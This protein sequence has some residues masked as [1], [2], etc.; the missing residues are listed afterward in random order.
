MRR[1]GCMMLTILLLVAGCKQESV[2]E[3]TSPERPDV[4]LIGFGGRCKGLS[5]DAPFN[6]RAYLHMENQ[7]LQVL[8]SAF[9][10]TGSTVAGFSF[11]ASVAQ[12][13]NDHDHLGYAEAEDLLEWIEENWIADF[14]DPT[15]IVIAAHSHGTLWASLLAMENPDLSIDYMVYIDGVCTWWEDDNLN[16]GD[17][18][19][20]VWQYFNAT[21]AGTYP[22]T[23]STLGGACNV[24]PVPGLGNRHL[25]D[26]V[27]ENVEIGVELRSDTI[28]SSTSDPTDQGDIDNQATCELTRWV[29]V[30]DQ[31]PNTRPDGS[32]EDLYVYQ[33]PEQDHC[34][35]AMGSG[36]AMQATADFLRNAERGTF[37][38]SLQAGEEE[39]LPTTSNGVRPAR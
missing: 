29:G 21:S 4:A 14:E 1:Y 8:A 36:A 11:A 37:P 7:T 31:T 10:D 23:L 35:I 32:L 9:M 34:E 6:N 28:L 5:C 33:S 30:A 12:A 38:T 13:W 25:K 18:G 24:Y 15:R 3:D 19:N 22:S 17:Y 20:I 27:P 26:V 2:N 16:H 39:R